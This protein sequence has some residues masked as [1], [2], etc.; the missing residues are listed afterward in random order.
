ML[1]LLIHLHGS[2]EQRRSGRKDGHAHHSLAWLQ[3]IMFMIGSSSVLAATGS[4]YLAVGSHGADDPSALCLR[5]K[6]SD[7][8]ISTCHSLTAYA[9]HVRFSSLS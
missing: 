1:R 9:T 2:I 8:L 4:V 3:V 5:L 7:S 6:C